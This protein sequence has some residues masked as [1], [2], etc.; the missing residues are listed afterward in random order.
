M[1]HTVND[2]FCKI[3]LD[4]G[5]GLLLSEVHIHCKRRRKHAWTRLGKAAA[6]ST[7]KMTC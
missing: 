1:I 6:G 4:D 2:V 7:W 5:T 3:M